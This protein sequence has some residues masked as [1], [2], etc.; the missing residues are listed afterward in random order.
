MTDMLTDPLT[1]P[2]LVEAE[3]ILAE[4][5]DHARVGGRRAAA[6]RYREAAALYEEVAQASDPSLVRARAALYECAS[7]CV[8][9]A[10]RCEGEA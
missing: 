2:R 8:S 3:S 4:A 9:R 10:V 5:E 7:A 1:D 6:V